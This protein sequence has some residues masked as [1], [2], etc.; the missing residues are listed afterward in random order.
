MSIAKGGS[1]AQRLQALKGKRER[2]GAVL[3]TGGLGLTGSWVAYYLAAAGKD[4]IVLDRERLRKDYLDPVR[5]HI[6]FYPGDPTDIRA[7]F[8]VFAE[9]RNGIE[10][11]IHLA[12]VETHK[13]P[14]AFA[15]VNVM[16]LVN[17]LEAA[18]L[19]E[20]NKVVMR[21]SGAVYGG[22]GGPLQET[23]PSHPVDLYG[24]SMSA[25]EMIGLQYAKE[26]GMLL[27]IVRTSQV[28]GPGKIPGRGELFSPLA[29][30]ASIEMPSGW[31]D[32][33][34]LTYVKDAARGILLVYQ[35]EKTDFQLFNI[36]GGVAY[37]MEDIV[38]AVKEHCT[39]P[40]KVKIGSGLSSPR[41]ASGGP[42][43][44]TRAREV[45]GYR[46]EYNLERGLD[47]YAQWL[48]TRS[49]VPVEAAT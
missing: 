41:F 6:R 36:S 29:G 38:E 45:L 7:A 28:Y 11:V 47:E 8:E 25:A 2:G 43:D 17:M 14:Y 48:K 21:S 1:V 37:S 16:G 5:E 26:A 49:A 44:L 23:A 39:G 42:L 24:A 35:A 18:R 27:R 19:H 20:V 3:L 40:V 34:D 22:R 33:R 46:P 9:N 30:E 4:V 15:S 31:D 10:G 13:W 12:R 32:R